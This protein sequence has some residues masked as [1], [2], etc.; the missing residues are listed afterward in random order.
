[1]ALRYTLV[2]IVLMLAVA[3]CSR[4]SAQE[5]EPVDPAVS[6]ALAGPLLTEP[7]LAAMNG[8]GRALTGTGVASA[9]IP[10]NLYTP[11][12][13]A[14]AKAEAKAQLGG[15]IPAAPTASGSEKAIGGQTAL[16]SLRR[17]YGKLPCEGA[18]NWSAIWATRLPKPL[19]P[20][21]RGHVEEALGA[22]DDTCHLRAVTYRI[23]VTPAEALDFHAAQAAEAGLSVDHRA[24]GD[25]HALVTRKGALSATI[26]MRPGPDGLTE[27]HIV[28]SGG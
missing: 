23:G 4:D 5:A 10:A 21:P 7:D 28:T 20:Y 22:D 25:A 14:A 17:A 16:D 13:I 8:A 6:A 19:A 18:A 1:M 15:A 2:P 3:G 26:Y 11:E 12:A 24:D 9:Q 27:V